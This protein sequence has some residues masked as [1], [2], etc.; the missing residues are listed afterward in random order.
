MSEERG[1]L[2][3]CSK[4]VQWLC[5]DFQY[6]SLLCGFLNESELCRILYQRINSLSRDGADICIHVCNAMM[7][8]V[9][10]CVCLQELIEE[11]GKYHVYIH[12]G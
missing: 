3:T 4:G 10:V 9:C 5:V 1:G 6:S 7:M 2:S 8:C 12:C 11:L